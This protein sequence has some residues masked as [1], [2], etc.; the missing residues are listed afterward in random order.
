[1]LYIIILLPQPKTASQCRMQIRRIFDVNL[2]SKQQ[3]NVMDLLVLKFSC[4]GSQYL[5]KL[6]ACLLFL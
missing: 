4:V 6:S 5:N 1:M 3:Y 2:F